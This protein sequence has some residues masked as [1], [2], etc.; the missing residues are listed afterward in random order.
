MNQTTVAKYVKQKWT[1]LKELKDKST[2]IVGDFNIF[3]VTD[4]I[5]QKVNKNIEELNK[6]INQHSGM[7][8]YRLLLPTHSF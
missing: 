7:T 4:K 2:I 8:I 1:E 3:L 6:T 5:K